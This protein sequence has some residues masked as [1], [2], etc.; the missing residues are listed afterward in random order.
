MA[1]TSPPGKG[2]RAGL[3]GIESYSAP[4]VRGVVPGRN[5]KMNRIHL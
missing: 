2:Q 1:A 4:A 3:D 5:K